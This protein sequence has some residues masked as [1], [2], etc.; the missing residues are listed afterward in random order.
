MRGAAVLVLLPKTLAEYL[1]DVEQQGLPQ[2]ASAL[3]EYMV[4]NKS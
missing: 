2:T 3:R 1:E 4:D